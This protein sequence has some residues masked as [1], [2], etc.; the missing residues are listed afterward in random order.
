MLASLPTSGQESKDTTLASLLTLRKEVK[1]LNLRLCPNRDKRKNINKNV[2]F[3]CFDS[4][5]I[6]GIRK[7]PTFVISF[8]D[9]IRG[10]VIF[11]ITL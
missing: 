8:S 10:P 11:I 7:Q 3:F 6:E 1:T 4:Q 5:V 2:T 9:N